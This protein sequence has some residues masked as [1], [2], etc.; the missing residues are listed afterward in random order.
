[1]LLEKQLLQERQ[2]GNILDMNIHSPFRRTRWNNQR[3]NLFRHKN[4]FFC[5]CLWAWI[6]LLFSSPTSSVGI[7]DV[8][9]LFLLF[10][11]LNSPKPSLSYQAFFPII[12]I[13]PVYESNFWLFW[14][15]WWHLRHGVLTNLWSKTLCL[16]VELE[17]ASEWYWLIVFIKGAAFIQL[18]LLYASRQHICSNKAISGPLWS[19]TVTYGSACSLFPNPS[20]PILA[21]NTFLFPNAALFINSWV[22]EIK[23][24]C[25]SPREAVQLLCGLLTQIS[26]FI[27][28]LQQCFIGPDMPAVQECLTAITRQ[29]SI[30]YLD[31]CGAEIPTRTRKLNQ[32]L[33]LNVDVS[34]AKNWF[35]LPPLWKCLMFHSILLYYYIIGRQITSSLTF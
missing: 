14:K 2:R 22:L 29:C 16:F 6:Q 18:Q 19:S 12:C 15:E 26:V 9:V 1:M 5:L 10:G 33:V 17:I 8:H 32:R 11:T 23:R 4:S 31:F 3:S 28:G 35:S 20:I 7:T 25:R 24:S 21:L 30:L 13:F 34:L 27:L